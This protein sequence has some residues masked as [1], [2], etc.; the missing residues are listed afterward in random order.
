M[1][2]VMAPTSDKKI[3]RSVCRIC[4]GGCGALITVQDNKV[5][6]VTGDPQ[7]PMSKGWMCVK[8]MNSVEIAN[9]PDRLHTPLRRKKGKGGGW[10]QISWDDALTEISQ[11]L[12]K[13]RAES[14]PEAI[15]LGQGTGRHHYMHVVRFANALGT[16]NWYEPGLAQCFIPRIHASFMTYG[17]FPVCD[18]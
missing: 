1:S 17:N 13:I 12:Q 16:P 15:A 3:V 9:H 4:H 8:G 14:G 5:V 10:Q 7:S 2:T 18:Y 11:H 6:K